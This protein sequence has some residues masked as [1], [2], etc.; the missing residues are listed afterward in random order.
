MICFGQ[1]LKFL[2][3][4]DITNEYSKNN[5]QQQQTRRFIN[6]LTIEMSNNEFIEPFQW[7]H[8]HP[9]KFDYCRQI[10][11]LTASDKF[12]RQKILH[13]SRHILEYFLS[14]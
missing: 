9:P 4:Q 13:L 11:F 7:L 5:H 12:H 2:F 1:R 3:D 6:N 14:A 10:I 8:D